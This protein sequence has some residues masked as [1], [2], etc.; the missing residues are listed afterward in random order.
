[1]QRDKK[2]KKTNCFCL[3]LNRIDLDSLFEGTDFTVNISRAKF[4]ELNSEYFKGTLDPV[5]KALCDAKLDKGQMHEVVLVGGSTR[6]PMIQKLLKSFFANK[7][8]NRSINPDEAVAYGAG[9]LI[10]IHQDRGKPCH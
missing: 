9:D 5:A 7:E 1:M 6:I 4:E 3:L 2:E 10:L 8:L